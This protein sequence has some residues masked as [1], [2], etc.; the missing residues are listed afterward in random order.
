ML[1]GTS[2]NDP[3]FWL[4]HC[5]IDR[6]WGVWQRKHVAAQPYLPWSGGPAGYNVNDAMAPW[7]GA[8]AVTPA[9]L[10]D[11][12]SPRNGYQYDDDPPA[13]A[14]GHLFDAHVELL[15]D[16][17]RSPQPPSKVKVKDVFPMFPMFRAPDPGEPQHG[18]H[19][20][21]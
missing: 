16:L 3:I 1:P 18:G 17:R 10:L 20:H 5:F 2:P 11:T 12:R 15:A 4:N 14:L 7:T 8:D 13:A 9:E 19:H 21:H 6:L